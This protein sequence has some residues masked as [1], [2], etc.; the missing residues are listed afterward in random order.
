MTM[1]VDESQGRDVLASAAASE[2]PAFAPPRI[3]ATLGRYQILA[4][5]GHGAMATVFRARDSQLGRD[6]AIKVM[7][8]VHA[9]RG[10]AGERFRREAHAVAALKHPGIVE[11]YDFAEATEE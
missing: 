5:L 11:I 2:P 9:T 3:G 10:G 1:V 8:L 4:T 6:V 7:G